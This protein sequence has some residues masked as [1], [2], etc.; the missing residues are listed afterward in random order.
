MR[1]KATDFK[2]MNRWSTL[3]TIALIIFFVGACAH[4]QVG[5]APG[6]KRETGLH[7]ISKPR[8]LIV[9]KSKYGSTRQYAQWIQKEIPSDLVDVETEGKPEFAKYDVII[10]GSYM[11]MGRIV[12]APLMI[13]AW[14]V[15]KGMKI[16]LYTTSGT[17]PQHPNIQKIFNKNLPED[18]RKEITYFPLPGRMLKNDLSFFDKILVAIGQIIEKDESLRQLMSND[19]DEMKG[20]NLLPLLEY[21]KSCLTNAEGIKS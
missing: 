21:I 7:G 19:F 18:I 9:Y 10:F 3:L 5:D 6:I 8:V 14:N 16:V 17:P 15:I 4:T 12:I 1:E 2:L 13:E 11:R 20:E